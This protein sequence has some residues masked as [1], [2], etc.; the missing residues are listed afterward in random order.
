MTGKYFSDSFWHTNKKADGR[1]RHTNACSRVCGPECK[2]VEACFE[3]IARRHS[4]PASSVARKLLME[5]ELVNGN[6]IQAA[7]ARNA[8]GFQ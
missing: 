5:E 8:K 2:P 1:R 4:A 3:R 6:M 7:N